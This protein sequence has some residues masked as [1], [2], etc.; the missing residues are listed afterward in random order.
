MTITQEKIN[1]NRQILHKL[2]MSLHKK[3]LSKEIYNAHVTM[4]TVLKNVNSFNFEKKS[5]ILL[6]SS[7]TSI[8]M[9][10]SKILMTLKFSTLISVVCSE[11]KRLMKFNIKLIS[12]VY[13]DE[14]RL[15]MII[16]NVIVYASKRAAIK[17]IE[18]I[19]L[20]KQIYREK[21]IESLKEFVDFMFFNNQ[22]VIDIRS[23][24]IIRD[25]NTMI[26]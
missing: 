13:F 6:K 4:L 23:E 24:L 21:S 5:E 7:A 16:E 12:I 25:E 3:K 20:L 18:N 9:K 8:K 10:K 22:F 11:K 26:H 1:A 19:L 17:I 2:Q 15:I 14:K